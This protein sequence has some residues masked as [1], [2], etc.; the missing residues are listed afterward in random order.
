LEGES[1]SLSDFEGKVLVLSFCGSWS[2]P[3]ADDLR[4]L[5]SVYQSLRHKGFIALSI[6]TDRSADSL[7]H[8][9]AKTHL[10][11]QVVLDEKLIVTKSRY[12]V[13]MV[14]TAFLID[15]KGIVQKRFFGVQNWTS[16]GL[17][18]EIEKLL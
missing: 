7:R 13:F 9:L 15:R 18:S 16:P 14:P 6:S 12:K 8:F 2:P 10:G 17:T 1:F 3:C 4:S 5:N 11:F